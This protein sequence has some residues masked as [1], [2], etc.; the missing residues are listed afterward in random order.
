MD[1]TFVKTI[2]K[3]GLV[4]QGLLGEPKKRTK[5]AIL[6]IH[7][8]A[9]NFF[10]N[11]FLKTM[12]FEYPKHGIS[13]LTVEHRGSEIIR[14]FGNKIGKKTKYKLLGNA[15]EK[16]EDSYFDIDAWVK[17]LKKRGYKE[18][19]LQ[20]HSLGPTKIVHYLN[21]TKEKIKA[22]IFISPSDIHGLVL[23]KKTYPEH[24]KLLNEAKGI[25]KKGKNDLL[26]NSLWDTYTLSAKTYINILDNKKT[27]IF[28]Y[29]KP[30]LGFSAIKKIKIPILSFFGTKDDG[31][32]TDPYFSS[33]LLKKNATNCSKYVGV[34][35]KGAKHSF[36]GFEKRITDKVI[37]FIKS[38]S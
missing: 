4:F 6:H 3:D 22:T 32:V 28:N 34:V 13:F 19:Y 27:A 15:Y 23:H 25:I 18:I 8:M 1:V 36:E 17:F 11:N 30:S 21:K 20:G 10:E 7:G 2:T 5:K 14:W 38:I 37:N 35:F 16:F 26:K 31:L 33:D 9:G 12:M 29:Y 24:K